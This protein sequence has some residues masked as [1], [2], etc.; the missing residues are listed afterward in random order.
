MLTLV[1]TLCVGARSTLCVVSTDIAAERL[2]LCSHAER[3][4]K[5]HL[6]SMPHSG[7]TVTARPVAELGI[8]HR[9]RIGSLPVLR[10]WW[11]S[12]GAT[13]TT[14][15]CAS[16]RSWSPSTI[17]AVAGQHDTLRAR[18]R[19]NAW[20]CGRRA[21]LRI[22]ASRSSAPC[23]LR[24]SASARGSRRRL[25]SSLRWRGLRC[26]FALAL[27]VSQTAH[28]ELRVAATRF[29]LIC[30]GVASSRRWRSRRTCTRPASPSSVISAVSPCS[31]IHVISGCSSAQ[32]S[33]HP[34]AAVSR[35]RNAITP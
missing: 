27:Y 1:P 35:S 34:L 3:G 19:G 26:G 31:L 2:L 32:R 11:T 16:G 7:T 24:R 20:A 12:F 15:P 6:V 14:S 9:N 8:R 22:R 17:D 23:R 30:R 13:N 29:A 10:N 33:R 21:R 25:P 5:T 4:N 28:R 18:S